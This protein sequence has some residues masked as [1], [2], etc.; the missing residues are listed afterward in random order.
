M[1][2]QMRMR[3]VQQSDLFVRGDISQRTCTKT[4]ACVRTRKCQRSSSAERG[5]IISPTPARTEVH[6][7]TQNRIKRRRIYEVIH[8]GEKEE[9]KVERKELNN[10]SHFIQRL[11]SRVESSVTGLS[12]LY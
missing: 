6:E 10:L 1:D 5:E 7:Y 8:R 3:G 12:Y 9:G 2:S 11:L 4:F